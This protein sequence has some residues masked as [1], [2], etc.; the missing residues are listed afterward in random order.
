MVSY[1][2][3]IK[4]DLSNNR[5]YGSERK[6]KGEHAWPSREESSCKWVVAICTR[7]NL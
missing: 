3:C 4:I 5:K 7:S 6:S 1:S 2:R